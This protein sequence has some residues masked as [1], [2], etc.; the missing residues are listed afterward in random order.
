MPVAGSPPDPERV[1][2][3]VEQV[4]HLP[5]EGPGVPAP[6]VVQ[7]AE[8]RQQ[9]QVQEDRLGDPPQGYKGHNGLQDGMTVPGFVPGA[10][11]CR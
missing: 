3:M 10:A 1:D 8:R 5:Y 2:D 11:P 6:V 4:E 7:Q 9:Q